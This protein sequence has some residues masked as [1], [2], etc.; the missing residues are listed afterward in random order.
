MPAPSA[1]FYIATA[2]ATA[3]SGGVVPHET[4]HPAWFGSS[5]RIEKL[6]SQGDKVVATPMM[7]VAE[8]TEKCPKGYAVRREG[9][10]Q[11]GADVY[12]TW[13]LNCY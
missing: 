5:V 11:R 12:L 1:L 7:S 2:A 3:F 13:T 9:R 6:Y 8:A 4:N 10:E